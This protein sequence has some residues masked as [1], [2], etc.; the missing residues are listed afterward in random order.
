[1]F[2]PS[3][4]FLKKIFAHENM[5]HYNFRKR[6]FFIFESFKLQKL[7]K[8][9]GKNDI[10]PNNFS[11]LASKIIDLRNQLRSSNKHFSILVPK[12]VNFEAKKTYRFTCFWL[13]WCH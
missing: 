8:E 1:M 5:K 3:T 4:M 10:V 6:L 13:I 9:N 12:Y 7:W 11:Y 2:S